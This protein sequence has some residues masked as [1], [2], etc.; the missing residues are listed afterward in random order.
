MRNAETKLK[1]WLGALGDEWPELFLVGG[2]VRDRLLGRPPGDMDLMC[3]DAAGVARRLAQARNGVAIPFEKKPGEP[4]YRVVDRDDP[5]NHLDLAEMRGESLLAD[6]GHRDFTINAMAMAVRTG[7]ISPDIVD[8]FQG[9]RDIEGRLIRMTGPEAFVQ[10][11]LRMLRAFRFAA[12]LGFDI[13]PE[14]LK[15]MKAEAQRLTGSASERVLS[16]LIRIYRSPRSTALTLLMDKGGLLEVL[17]PEILA[18]KGCTQNSFHHRDVWGHSLAVL[19]NCEYILAHLERFF[20]E[21]SGLMRENLGQGNRVPVLKMAA[22]LHDVAKPATR[23]IDGRTGRITFY[24]HDVQGAEMAEA[25]G[26]RLKMS[27]E[28]REFFCLLVREHLHVLNFSNP[29]ITKPARMRWFRKLGDDAIPVIILGMADI[30]GT[31]GTDS[32]EQGRNRHLAWSEAAAAEYYR[33]VKRELERKDLVTG[34]DL[35]GL[36][37]KPGPEMGKVLKA[38]REAQDAGE[39]RDREEAMGLARRLVSG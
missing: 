12:E 36:G 8:P 4:C 34:K 37:M 13:E 7:G 38:V 3:R 16:E 21:V 20:G 25:I 32:T 2:A 1:G 26:R 29:D 35:I 39:V 5:D 30:K 24:G 18:M 22:L 23:A 11:P 17:F 28:D 31:L 9:V 33:S 15:V 19:E 14:T 6:L 27:N 10:D